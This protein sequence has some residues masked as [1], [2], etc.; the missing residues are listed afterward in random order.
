MSRSPSD[1]GEHPGGETALAV[2]VGD[3]R[4]HA[5]TTQQRLPRIESGACSSSTSV[6]LRPATSSG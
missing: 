3:E 4:R 2:K 1:L 5:M 6:S